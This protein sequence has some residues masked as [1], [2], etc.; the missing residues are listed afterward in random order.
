MHGKIQCHRQQGVSCAG[1]RHALATQPV[2]FE[3][4]PGGHGS[5]ARTHDTQQAHDETHAQGAMHTRSCTRGL[6]RARARVCV[7]V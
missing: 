1:P 4:H 5:C 7:C 6:A 2:Q 3:G